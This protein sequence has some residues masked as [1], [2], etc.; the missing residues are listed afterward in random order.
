MVN[1]ATLR[2]PVPKKL[3]TLIGDMSVSYALLESSLQDLAASLIEEHQRICQIILCEGSLR[4]LLA[5]IES[6]YKERHG[7][8]GDYTQLKN[9]L[10]NADLANQRRNAIIHSVWVAGDNAKSVVRIKMTAKKTYR[11]VSEKIDQVLLQS[12]ID[13]IQELAQNI[14]YFRLRLIQNKKAFNNPVRGKPKCYF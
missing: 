3:L 6:L 4:Q 14:L 12:L 2:H 10:K 1:M 5:M 8:D 13:E 9:F 7:E 11:V